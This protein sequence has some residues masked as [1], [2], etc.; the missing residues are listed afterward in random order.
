MVTAL[1]WGCG[2]EAW[3]EAGQAVPWAPLLGVTLGCLGALL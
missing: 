1:S 3:D 2:G